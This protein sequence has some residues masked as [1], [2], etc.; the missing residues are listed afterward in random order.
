MILNYINHINS[1]RYNF[2]PLKQLKIRHNNVYHIDVL[3]KLFFTSDV[4][5]ITLFYTD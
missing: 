4:R 1:F 5:E 3:I 2:N